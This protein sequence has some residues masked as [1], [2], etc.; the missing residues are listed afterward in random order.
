MLCQGS[1]PFVVRKSNPGIA[2]MVIVPVPA[3]V[4]L[5]A[6]PPTVAEISNE[7]AVKPLDIT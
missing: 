3:V 2:G 5:I 6:V 7:F 1:S 4:V